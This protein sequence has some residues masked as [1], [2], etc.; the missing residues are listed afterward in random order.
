MLSPIHSQQLILTHISK[1][2]CI[3][4]VYAIA[5]WKQYTSYSKPLIYKEAT[6]LGAWT[7]LHNCLYLEINGDPFNQ[8]GGN[9][10][11]M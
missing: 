2:I 7:V 10:L 8:E 1:P 4:E 6:Y 3:A 9:F 11:P 5:E